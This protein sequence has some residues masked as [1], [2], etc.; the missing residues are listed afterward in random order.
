M[1]QI[2]VQVR[3]GMFDPISMSMEDFEFAAL[4]KDDEILAGHRP[5]RV[6]FKKIRYPEPPFDS[7][8]PKYLIY[9]YYDGEVHHEGS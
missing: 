6:F 9:A 4:H 3:G 7:T 8:L 5:V 1:A 2:E